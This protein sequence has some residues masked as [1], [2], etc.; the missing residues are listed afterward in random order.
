MR[1]REVIAGLAAAG[2]W[3]HAASAQ[4]TPLIGL[5]SSRSPDE[6]RN[7]LSAFR[8][9]LGESGYVEGQNVRVEYRFGLGQYDAMVALARELASRPLAVLISVG[10]DPA[11]L[12]AR[13]VEVTM[14]VVSIFGTDPVE[15]GLVTSLNRP[16]GNITGFSNLTL[17]L[18]PKRLGLLRELVPEA[19]TAGVLLNPA[20]PAADNQLAHLR[21]AA[22]SVGLKLHVL[23]ASTD[24]EIEAAFAGVE[25]YG[26][27][28][29]VVGTDPFF[30]TVRH[31]LADLA[32]RHRLP[33]MYSFREFVE[34]GGLMSYG[35]DLF[36]AYRQVGLYVGRV[37]KGERPA[38][39]PVIQPTKFEFVINLRTAKALGLATPP[40]LLARADEVIE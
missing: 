6:S 3:P 15:L 5:L 16:G 7:L 32:A 19:N 40:T 34:A 29:L 4:Q 30:H 37:L 36:D 21:E 23:K 28:A 31:K 20:R 9:G 24:T 11:A 17:S 38:D 10:G 2:A 14:P 26:L 18:E 27:S 35:V 12:A 25:R 8:R 1:R 13:A 39:L 22:G 33:A